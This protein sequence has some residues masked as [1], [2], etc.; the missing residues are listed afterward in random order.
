[1]FSSGA[2]EQLSISVSEYH[3]FYSLDKGKYD[4]LSLLPSTDCEKEVDP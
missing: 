3:G 4:R 1:M 2:S